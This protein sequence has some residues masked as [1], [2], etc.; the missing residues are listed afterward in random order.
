MDGGQVVCR[1]WKT[2]K[3]R[4]F[5]SYIIN[6]IGITSRFLLKVYIEGYPSEAYLIRLWS[7]KH[8]LVRK[9]IKTCQELSARQIVDPVF[10]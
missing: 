6:D 5:Y 9:S 4:F 1:S 8:S 10:L 7:W 3:V 2:P